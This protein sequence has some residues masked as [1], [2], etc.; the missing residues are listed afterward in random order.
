[1]QP[2]SL[3]L[4]TRKLGVMKRLGCYSVNDSFRMGSQFSWLLAPWPKQDSQRWSGPLWSGFDHIKYWGTLLQTSSFRQQSSMFKGTFPFS[5]KV[6]PFRSQFRF[7]S[8]QKCQLQRTEMALVADVFL[9]VAGQHLHGTQEAPVN[10]LSNREQWSSSVSGI[11]KL[12]A[13]SSPSL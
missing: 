8:D 11:R 5:R 12:M 13:P 3:I 7:W 9:C 6:V 4:Q 2:F 10:V 1:M